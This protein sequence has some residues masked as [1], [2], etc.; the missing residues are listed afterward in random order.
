LSFSVSNVLVRAMQRIS[1]PVKTV[2]AWAGGVV[3]G[4]LWVGAAGN[5]L[6][7]VGAGVWAAAA[8]LGLFGIVVMTAATQYGVTH[9]PLHRSAVILLFEL[10]VATVSTQLLTDETMLARE[11]LGGLLIVAAALVSSRAAA[12]ES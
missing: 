10:V 2:A 4:L 1:I 6:P 3:V 5:P 8:A 12:R 9:M 7:H 11:W